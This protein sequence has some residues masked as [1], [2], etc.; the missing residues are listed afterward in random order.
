MDKEQTLQL[1]TELQK[2]LVAADRQIARLKERARLLEREYEDAKMRE[3]NSSQVL[4]ELIERQHEQNVMLNRAQ[5]MLNQF[6][7]AIALTS[8]EFNEMAKALP[9]P[10]KVEFSDRITRINELFKKTGIQEGDLL[11]V[12]APA[13]NPAPVSE[14]IGGVQP[15]A[16]DQDEEPVAESRWEF[17]RRRRQQRRMEQQGGL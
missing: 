4:K 15:E 11:Q 3:S 10:K 6:H 14:E 2:K 12:D 13:G 8:V 1:I 5:I 9:E 17:L 7:E 16:E